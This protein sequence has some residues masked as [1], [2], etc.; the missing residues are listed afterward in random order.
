MILFAVITR[1]LGWK[2]E[3]GGKISYVTLNPNR[4]MQH[5]DY[6]LHQAEETYV[7]HPPEKWSSEVGRSCRTFKAV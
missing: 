3:F 7:L 1:G 5:S 2:M 4:S 6:Y